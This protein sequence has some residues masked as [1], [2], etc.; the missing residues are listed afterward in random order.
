M[1]LAET[2]NGRVQAR[3]S[4]PRGGELGEWLASLPEVE[5]R[6]KISVLLQLGFEMH[7]AMT[8]AAVH[9]ALNMNLG[10]AAQ[11]AGPAVSAL[12]AGLGPAIVQS[13][14][15]TLSHWTFDEPG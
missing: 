11:A 3:I 8:K 15:P 7:S 12:Q 5:R 13:P 2:D 1:S 4:I 6:V 14:E 10:Q 9:A